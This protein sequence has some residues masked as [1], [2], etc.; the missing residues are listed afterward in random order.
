MPRKKKP[1]SKTGWKEVQS[2]LKKN[3]QTKLALGVLALLIGFLIV[4]S[5]I[6]FTQNLFNPSKISSVVKN[7]SWNGEF[8][9]NLLIR[10]NTVALLSYNPGEEKVTLINIP[11]ETFLEVPHGFNFWQIRAVYDLGGD[12]LLLDTLTSFFGV[13]VDGFLDLASIKNQKSGAEVVDTLKQN[14]F[15][16]LNF[17]PSLKTNLTPWELLKLK[18]GI[19]SVRFDKIKKLDLDQLDVLDKEKLSDGTEVFTADPV[20]LDSILG[21]FADPAVVSEHKTIAVLNATDHPQLAQKWARLIT[22]LGG[23]VIITGNAN[24]RLLKTQVRGQESATLK[25]LKQ[26]FELGCQNTPKCDNIGPVDE[27]LVSSR[28]EIN[29]FLGEDYADK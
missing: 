26:I 17:L 19:A 10:T 5:L 8:N 15:S 18:S 13:P 9:I 12:S 28:A 20:K 2:N 6:R 29:L 11:D 3:K 25:R 24:S 1:N 21:D 27:D 23:N 4:S 22:N 16:G 7:Y 14:P